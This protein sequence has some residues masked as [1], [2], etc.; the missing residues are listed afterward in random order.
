MRLRLAVLMTIIQTGSL[1]HRSAASNDS[2]GVRLRLQYSISNFNLILLGD[3][4]YYLAHTNIV[5]L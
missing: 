3:P 4:Q 5:D 1:A 2:V